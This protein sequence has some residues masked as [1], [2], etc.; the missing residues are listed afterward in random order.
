MKALC[1]KATEVF[2]SIRRCRYEGNLSE[3]ANYHTNNDFSSPVVA[4]ECKG[5]SSSR[6]DL[7]PLTWSSFSQ[8]LDCIWDVLGL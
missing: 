4:V 2:V 5:V 7:C 1:V 8:N 3:K 6:R